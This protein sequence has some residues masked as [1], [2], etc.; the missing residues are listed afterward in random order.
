MRRIKNEN[1]A[2][3]LMQLRFMPEKKRRKEL[4]AAEKLFA[5]IEPDKEYP[6][7]FVHFKITGFHSKGESEQ[8]LIKG[9]ELLEDLRIF[10]FKLS[11][12]LALPVTSQKEKIYTIE[13][14]A[15]TLG[16]STKTIYRWRK[17]GLIARKYI[18]DDGQRRLGFLQSM[19]DRFAKINPDLITKA[20][21]FERLT[22]K[23]KQQIIKQACTL[24]ARTKL[25]RYQ[26]ISRIAANI[27]KAHET[28]RYI[29]LQYEK[30]HPNKP[31]FGSS[32]GALNINCINRVYDPPS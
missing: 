16:V 1:L 18:F 6:F 13:D 4:D 29:L 32:S 9:D 3:L 2:Q 14:L 30:S 25:S 22:E 10:I 20:K 7:D 26:I 11:G 12:K 5:I 31:V 27:G 15:E 19:V 8:Q 28:V 17:K 23:Q 24:A 21:D